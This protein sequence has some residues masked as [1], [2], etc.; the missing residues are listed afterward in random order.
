MPIN[1]RM[2]KEVVVLSHRRRRRRR[3]SCNNRPL[4][5]D[6]HLTLSTVVSRA[7]GPSCL[8]LSLCL[9]SGTEAS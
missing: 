5:P 3:H 9:V 6:G 7:L 8:Q 4:A 1:A 2:L